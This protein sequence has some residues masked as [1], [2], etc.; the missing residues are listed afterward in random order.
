MI[1]LFLRLH[2]RLMRPPLVRRQSPGVSAKF[3]KCFLTCKNSLFRTVQKIPAASCA[4][5]V[6]KGFKGKFSSC[7][8]PTNTGLG[9][10]QGGPVVSVVTVMSSH[11][12]P[13]GGSVTF[14]EHNV[15]PLLLRK[16]ITACLQIHL[17]L[18]TFRFHCA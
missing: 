12:C 15:G 10:T 2:A 3:Y 18:A 9:L 4:V 14:C 6:Q 13:Q 7:V 1:S 8:L 17:R 5:H 11:L 16:C